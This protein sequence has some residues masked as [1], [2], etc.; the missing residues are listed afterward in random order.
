MAASLATKK[1]K[2]RPNGTSSLLQK[3][4]Y[5]QLIELLEKE[6]SIAQLFP[7]LWTQC[8]T[9]KDTSTYHLQE[10]HADP[11]VACPEG[12]NE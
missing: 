7:S 3:Y 1:K 5:F 6:V 12:F 11:Q 8:C 10:Q 9:H 4:P 2:R